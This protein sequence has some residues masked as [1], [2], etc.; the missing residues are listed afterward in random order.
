[1]IARLCTLI[2]IVGSLRGQDFSFSKEKEAAIGASM[3]ATIGD[4]A[5]CLT[6]PAVNAY[7]DRLGQRLAGQAN[8][9]G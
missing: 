3:A 8:Q 5:S 2:L 1:M 6:D 7:I 4:G 9:V